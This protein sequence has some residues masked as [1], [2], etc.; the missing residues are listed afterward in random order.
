[1]FHGP[2][3]ASGW[4]FLGDGTLC[5]LKRCLHT[6][7][8]DHRAVHAKIGIVERAQ[9]WKLLAVHNLKGTV[10]EPRERIG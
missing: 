2:K 5:T 8:P 10:Y 7:D 3:A 4:A 6:Q 1:M 9:Q